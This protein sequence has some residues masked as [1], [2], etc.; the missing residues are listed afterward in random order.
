MDNLFPFEKQTLACHLALVETEHLTMG[1]QVPELPT[2]NLLYWAPKWGMHSSTE[3]LSG[4][5]LYVTGPE[6]ALKA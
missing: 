5:G 2:M 1:H 3:S 6:E 4:N